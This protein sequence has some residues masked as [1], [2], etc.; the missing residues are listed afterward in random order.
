MLLASGSQDNYIRMWRISLRDK[1][2]EDDTSTT[3]LKLKADSFTLTVEGLVSPHKLF[4]FFE[5]C[6]LIFKCFC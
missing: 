1:H 6:V 3:E 5:V 2:L 4:L